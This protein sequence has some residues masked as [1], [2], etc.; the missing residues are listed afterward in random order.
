MH[1]D[2][3]AGAPL[4]AEA[5]VFGGNSAQIGR[6]AHQIED[7][8]VGPRALE[9]LGELRRAVADHDELE[10]LGL[11]TIFSVCAMQGRL[12]SARPA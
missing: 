9:H 7:H 3:A 10:S 11:H 2:A 6:H 8:L 1:A 5:V 4:P 12:G